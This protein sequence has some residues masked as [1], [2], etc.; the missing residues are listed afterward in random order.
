MTHQ[1]LLDALTQLLGTEGVLADAASRDFYASD[2]FWQPG[3]RP[4]AILRPQT[5]DDAATAVRL[6]TDAGVG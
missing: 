2:V 1:P 5:A 4:I 6:A 3:M